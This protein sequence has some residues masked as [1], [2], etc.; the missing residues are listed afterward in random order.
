MENKKYNKIL[1]L[2]K[3]LADFDFGERLQIIEHL[4]PEFFL[5]LDRGNFQECRRITVD[6][7]KI[8]IETIKGMET[9]DINKIE[10]VTTINKIKAIINTKKEK[11]IK[12]SLKLNPKYIVEYGRENS[13]TDGMILKFENLIIKIHNGSIQNSKVRKLLDSIYNEILEKS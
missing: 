11:I 9:I 3:Q 10:D 4:A 1:E 6:D 12:L 5:E 7:K 13:Y 8:C 2:D